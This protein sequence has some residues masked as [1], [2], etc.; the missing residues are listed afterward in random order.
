L[1]LPPGAV[2]RDDPVVALLQAPAMPGPRSAREAWRAT[3]SVM[4]QP[5]RLRNRA[6]THPISLAVLAGTGAVVASVAMPVNEVF[7]L[8]FGDYGGLAEADPAGGIIALVATAG[9]VPL[10]LRHVAHGLR[11]IRLPSDRWTLAVMALLVLAPFPV[12]G[13]PWTAALSSLAIS[14]LV[15]LRPAVSVPLTAVFVATPLVVGVVSGAAVSGLYF[16]LVVSFRTA[17][18]FVLVWLVG[19]IRRLEAARRALAVQAVEQERLRIDDELNRALGSTLR[20]IIAVGAEL[21]PLAERDPDATRRGLAALVGRSR[22]ALADTRRIAAGFRHTSVRAELDTVL[23][24][25]RAAGVRSRLSVPAG[26][27]PETMDPTC[28]RDLYRALGDVL[29]GEG[30]R[31]CVLTVRMHDGEARFEL[32]TGL[33]EVAA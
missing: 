30:A 3:S 32:S 23:S 2:P 19:A 24:L 33:R 29:G 25:L 15:L 22:A 13:L 12:L 8:A 9:F 10:H 14:V 6:R 27:L 28:R 20:E 7:R 18:V 26:E 11:G 1:H 31:S 17:A 5:G 16:V 21:A 4:R